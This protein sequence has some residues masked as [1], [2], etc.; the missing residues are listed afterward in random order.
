MFSKF[1]ERKN[2]WEIR[3]YVRNRTKVIITRKVIKELEEVKNLNIWFDK[4]Y[5]DEIIDLY[6]NFYKIA[7]WKKDTIFEKNREE[8]IKIEAKLVEKSL[9]KLEEKVVKDL[10]DREIITPKLYIKFIEEIEDEFYKVV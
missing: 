4:K 9:L 2:W 5:F 3:K 7:E 6:K 1:L 10:Y 8:I